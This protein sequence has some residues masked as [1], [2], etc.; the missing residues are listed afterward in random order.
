MHRSNVNITSKTPS[1]ISLV[2]NAP[3]VTRGNGIHDVPFDYLV[4]Q[5]AARPVGDFPIRLS[6]VLAGN[7]NDMDELLWRECVGSTRTLD[8]RQ[9]CFDQRY[10]F[11][12]TEVFGLCC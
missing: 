6:W 4:C 9:S 2:Q 12:I 5:F 10:E 8:V 11:L 7:G 1:Q 3:H